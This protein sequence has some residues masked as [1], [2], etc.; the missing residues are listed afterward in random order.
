[1]SVNTIATGD[2][3]IPQAVAPEF[4]NC[5]Y[6]LE[7]MPAT[8]NGQKADRITDRQVQRARKWHVLGLLEAGLISEDEA[9]AKRAELPGE[10]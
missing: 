10:V 6:N 5:L 2:H 3:I 1:M 4:D 9:A 7:F 8:I